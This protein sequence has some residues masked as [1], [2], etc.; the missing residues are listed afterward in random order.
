[1]KKP[2]EDNVISYSEMKS[3]TKIKVP[4][5]LSA[6]ITRIKKNSEDIIDRDSYILNNNIY[7]RRMFIPSMN[8]YL[9]SF[10]SLLIASDV[11]KYKEAL[12]WDSFWTLSVFN[13]SQY[14]IFPS[15]DLSD[16][17]LALDYFVEN[18]S[19]FMSLVRSYDTRILTR[20]TKKYKTLEEDPNYQEYMVRLR[21][22]N[23]Y[24]NRPHIT[25]DKYN[26]IT[27]DSISWEDFDEYIKEL[28]CISNE[29]LVTHSL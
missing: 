8:K 10:S 4:K 25:K 22:V 6:A 17:L 11:L 5:T 27:F 24:K 26:W 7:G 23:P 20:L 18:K 12:E 2:T 1:M 29:L 14:N 21:K 16:K 15:R 9:I 3:S 19:D 28:E 13:T